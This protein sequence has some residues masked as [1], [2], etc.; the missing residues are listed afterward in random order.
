MKVGVMLPYLI[1]TTRTPALRWCTGVEDGPFSSLSI[2]ERITFHN[3][4]QIVML[5]AAAAATSRVRLYTHVVIAPIHP[6]IVLAKQLASIDMLSGGRLTVSVG[7]GG[8]EH[9]YVAAGTTMQKVFQRQDDCV[10]EMKRL[11]TG[12]PAFPGADPIGPA[13]TQPGGPPVFTSARGPKSVAR[14]T[15]WATGFTGATLSGDPADMLEEA[16]SFRDL[17][18]NAG[19]GPDPYM[20]T[21][22]FFAL[23]EGADARMRA[24]T[25]RYFTVGDQP[26]PPGLVDAMLSKVTNDAAVGTAI[27]GAE[28]AGFDELV[29]IPTTDNVADLDRLAELVARRG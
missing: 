6:P 14:A 4:D 5:A 20:M 24:V 3:V 26:P 1:P 22:V 28:A 19:G 21:S 9:D 27:D 11:W 13:A 12:A 29:F 23:G 10:A 2:G 7:T 18:G 25:D 15:K 16:R 8:R 17:W